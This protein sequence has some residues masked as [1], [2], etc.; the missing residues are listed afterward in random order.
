[1]LSVC[2]SRVCSHLADS[3]PSRRG[4]S[5][6]SQL[7]YYYSCSSR[8]LE[9]LHFDLFGQL[10]LAGRSLAD[11]PPGR[12]GPSPRH[13]LLADHPRIGRGPSVIRGALLEGRLSFS[14]R[15]SVTRGP[16]AWCLAELLSPLLLVFRFRFWIV[17]GL[18]L[19]LVG[20]L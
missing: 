6:W 1:L 9:G 18:L 19:G 16:S 11:C 3:P 4:Q 8:V 15:P 5:A 20:P 12:R 7:A 10:F 13:Q 2:C 17:W 14:D